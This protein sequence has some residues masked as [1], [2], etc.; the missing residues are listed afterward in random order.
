VDGARA[1]ARAAAVQRFAA[2]LALV[3]AELDKQA[4]SRLCMYGNSN[5][6][7]TA[8]ACLALLHCLC[9]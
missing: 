7:C 9:K 1:K 3:R 4:R 6:R 5:I 2:A 8:T